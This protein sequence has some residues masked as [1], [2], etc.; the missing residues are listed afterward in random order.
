MKLN[1]ST[2]RPPRW[3]LP[4]SIGALLTLS[5]PLLTGCSA[6]SVL[7]PGCSEGQVIAKGR[8]ADPPLAGQGGAPAAGQGGRAGAEA[9][10]QGGAGG[11][12]G[13]G[14]QPVAP[15]FQ[16]PPGRVNLQRDQ[17][18][19][20]LVTLE[21]PATLAVTVK[22]EDL[23]EGAVAAQPVTIT[24]G[25]REATLT[26]RAAPDALL[27]TEWPVK[28]RA[29]AGGLNAEAELKV[30]VQGAPGTP[31]ATFGTNGFES[32]STTL[33]SV[34]GLRTKTPTIARV[35]VDAAG[36]LFIYASF[37][38][39]DPSG[40][41][42]PEHELVAWH[43]SP[44]GV[45]DTAFGP[46]G[47]K[48]TTLG[49]SFERSVSDL[50]PQ[51]GG[52]L[53][54]VGGQ[55]SEVFEGSTFVDYS[56]QRVLA[57]RLLGDFSL[58]PSF[59][60]GGTVSTSVTTSQLGN[61]CFDGGPSCIARRA[62]RLADGGVVVTGPAGLF[63]FTALGTLDT[64]FGTANGRTPATDACRPSDVAVAPNG[65]LVAAGF[66]S[67]GINNGRACAMR[68]GPTGLPALTFGTNGIHLL[69]I[70]TS[71]DA[72]LEGAYR[73]GTTAEGALVVGIAA[74]KREGG[75]FPIFR[76][77]Q[78]VARL[79]PTG[80][81]DPVFGPE[82]RTLPFTIGDGTTFAAH[83]TTVEPAG[84]VVSVASAGGALYLTRD[85]AKGVRDEG[86]GTGGVAQCFVGGTPQRLSLVRRPDGRLVVGGIMTN[87]GGSF[88]AV[89]ARFWP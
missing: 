33:P 66:A 72:T 87:A 39:E 10:G 31:D 22:V 67:L 58:D 82:G 37:V 44:S 65:D 55:A 51:P 78:V 38:D 23:P 69:S 89:A 74:T 49:A 34:E 79:L 14:V 45:H 1:L 12:G 76:E 80:A 54:I 26:L 28:V 20:L 46:N 7:T 18:Q 3:P 25:A 64:A 41:V 40:Q 70:P 4:S 2:A 52:S 17:S 24:P 59:G 53:L 36:Q 5:L 30:W 42:D 84:S 88:S 71:S 61:A 68:F 62:T 63:K 27:G 35:Y 29:E 32:T 6:E 73:I 21:A 16:V 60:Q 75:S 43:F 48:V 85:D 47:R 19:G 13:G 8:C 77:S 11:G 83:D 57:G 56:A 50:L 15:R 9:G 86:F 81:I